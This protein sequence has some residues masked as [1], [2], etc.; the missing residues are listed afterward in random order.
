MPGDCLFCKIVGGDVAA[1]I[2]AEGEHTLAFRD[3]APQAPTHVLVISKAHHANV[4][5]LAAA[6]PDTLVELHRTAAAVAEAEG[7]ADTGY[8]LVYNTGR[9]G[10]QSVDHVHLHVLGGRAMG[11]P[12]G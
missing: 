5:A 4:T 6:G 1:T 12:P 9:D 8:R 2:V 3:V 7:I 10:Q 11:W